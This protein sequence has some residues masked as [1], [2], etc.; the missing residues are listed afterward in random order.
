MICAPLANREH[1][2]IK[3]DADSLESQ[4]EVIR[5]EEKF[6]KKGKR[7]GGQACST[8]AKGKG[9]LI[10]QYTYKA[11]LCYHLSGFYRKRKSRYS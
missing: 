9:V 7:P 5:Q 2:Y 4:R 11:S 1:K 3:V 8:D 6:E 10:L